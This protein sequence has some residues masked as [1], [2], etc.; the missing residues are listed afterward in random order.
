MAHPWLSLFIAIYI[1]I[2]IGASY[3]AFEKSKVEDVQA[4][5]CLVA[6]VWIFLIVTW[7]SLFV[8]W[9]IKKIG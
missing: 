6:I 7:P 2:G 5:G 3:A 4:D 9:L 1:L 8:Y